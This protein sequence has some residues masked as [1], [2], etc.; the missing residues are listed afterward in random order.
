MK[1]VFILLFI[2]I[3]LVSVLYTGIRQHRLSQEA[4]VTVIF[5]YDEKI[6]ECRELERT[7]HQLGWIFGREPVI[8]LTYDI[9]NPQRRAA[10]DKQL[11]HTGISTAQAAQY[12]KQ[13]VLY[14]SKNKQKLHTF[15]TKDDL[16]QIERKIR[17]AL[18]LVTP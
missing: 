1:K 15:T 4:F 14:S 6:A 9:S 5:Y 2:I 18:Q 16:N 7:M 13:I 12:V 10:S 11:Q 17:G 3:T 8:F